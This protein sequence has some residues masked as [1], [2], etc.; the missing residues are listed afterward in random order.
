MEKSAIVT[1]SKYGLHVRHLLVR[2]R[3]E[4]LQQTEILHDL[5]SRRMHRIAAEVAQEILVFFEHD[6]IHAGPRHQISEHHAG[7]TAAHH[8]AL[9]SHLAHRSSLA[10]TPL[11]RRNKSL[12]CENRHDRLHSRQEL[13]GWRK[14][15]YHQ[16]SAIGKSER[17][18]R[19][20]RD[21]VLPHQT[22]RKLLI[23]S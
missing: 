8:A 16:P 13:V 12:F 14:Q 18:S 15:A 20:H 5:R 22:N 4:L 2:Q 9:C 1:S 7:G 11:D 6:R 3:K 17:R 10:R 21:A 19:V 23:G